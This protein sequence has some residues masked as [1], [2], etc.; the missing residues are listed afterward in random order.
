[1]QRER[2]IEGLT[3]AAGLWM[4]AAVGMAVGLQMYVLSVAVTLIVLLLLIFNETG[5]VKSK[6]GVEDNGRK[7]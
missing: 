3:T 5:W 7:E 4:S 6:E 2:H 1:M